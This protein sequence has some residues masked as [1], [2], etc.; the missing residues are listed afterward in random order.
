MPYKSDEVIAKITEFER[1]N[2]TI[3]IRIYNWIKKMGADI[4]T[5]V[6]HS[7]REY[8]DRDDE[9]SIGEKTVKTT[10]MLTEDEMKEIVNEAIRLMRPI[11]EV[12]R[13]KLYKY[14]SKNQLK[15]YFYEVYDI[16]V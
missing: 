2:I 11:Q 13:M 6:R 12:I 16:E 8:I 5:I 7:L 14:Y 4:S 15:S 10:I 9:C 1:F 3:P